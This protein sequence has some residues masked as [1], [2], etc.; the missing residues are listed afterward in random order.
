MVL[1]NSGQEYEQL[2]KSYSL[3]KPYRIIPN[4][5]DKKI[6]TPGQATQKNEKLVIC[7]A[8]IEGIKN[9]LNLI[10]AL[11][12]TCYRLLLIGDASPNQ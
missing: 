1:P 8:R 12:D 9:Q 5:I 4:G 7:A 2:T 3:N 10:R 6:F 11:N